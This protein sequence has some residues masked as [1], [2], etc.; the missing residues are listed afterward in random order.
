M[1]LKYAICCVETKDEAHTSFT[2]TENFH[3][4]YYRDYGQRYA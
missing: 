2:L 1:R 3:I 4:L